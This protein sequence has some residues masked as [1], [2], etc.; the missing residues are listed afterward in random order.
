MSTLPNPPCRSTPSSSYRPGFRLKQTPIDKWSI[1]EKLALASSVHRSGDQNWYSVSRSLKCFG[2]PNRPTD[3]FSQKNCALQ[4]S[5]LLENVETPKRKRGE[6]GENTAQD[7]IVLEL[8]QK[9]IDELKELLI[10]EKKECIDLR[11]EL[12]LF[13]S[14]KAGPDKFK[15][16][17]ERMQKEEKN[18]EIEKE[19]HEK[20]LVEREAKIAQMKANRHLVMIRSPKST[21][22]NPAASPNENETKAKSEF[23]DIPEKTSL[24]E[25][26]TV[27]IE[28]PSTDTENSQSTTPTQTPTTT[29]Q[30]I[31]LTQQLPQQQTQAQ[32]QPQ[33]QPQLQP[34]PQTQ[35]QI[36]PQPQPQPPIQIQTQAQTP[37]S[38]QTPQ[39]PEKTKVM[40]SPVVSSPSTS[41]LLTHLLQSPSPSANVA[42]PYNILSPSTVKDM[43]QRTPPSTTHGH[44]FPSS[45]I[46]SPTLPR[47]PATSLSASNQSTETIAVENKTIGKETSEPSSI[48]ARDL[49]SPPAVSSSPTLTKLLETTSTTSIKAVSSPSRETDQTETTIQDVEMVEVKENVPEV[50][51]NTANTVEQTETNVTNKVEPSEESVIE[52]QSTDEAKPAESEQLTKNDADVVTISDTSEENTSAVTVV[53]AK[54]P[55]VTLDATISTVVKAVVDKSIT[56]SDQITTEIK[57]ELI[58]SKESKDESSNKIDIKS[59]KVEDK[60]E[61]DDN[62]PATPAKSVPP[63]SISSASASRKRKRTSVQVAATPPTAPT[64]RSVR[65]RTNKDKTSSEEEQAPIDEQS[66]TT[67]AS[68]TSSIT[69]TTSVSTSVVTT[70]SVSTPTSVKKAPIISSSVLPPPPPPQTVSAETSAGEESSDNTNISLV[71]TLIKVPTSAPTTAPTSKASSVTESA[72]NSPASAIL[73]SEEIENQKESKMW[74]KS[75][76]LLW[77][78]ATTHKFSTL[79]AHPVTDSEAKGYSTVVYRPMDLCTI[80]K[81]IENGQIKTTAEFQRDMMLM[82]QNAIMYNSA[83]HDVHQMAVEM[84]K[85]ILEGIEDFIETQQKSTSTTNEPT[86]PRGR[87]SNISTSSDAHDPE[88]AEL[89][90]RK[91]ASTDTEPV[92][93]PSSS[94]SKTK[95]KN[96]N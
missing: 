74:K 32:P 42:V 17:F 94:K 44:F 35:A 40:P 50:L 84:Q 23:S 81:K 62:P 77:R 31:P 89:R 53:D 63:V 7:L 96:P 39:T 82:F 93:T 33:P 43:Q 92:S 12:D 21:K 45:S 60:S 87:R 10:K 61:S 65:V 16:V 8:T 20:W 80:R 69:I 2:E 59:V 66:S 46:T 78:Q 85:E 88:S 64:R 75:I 30:Q 58:E 36:Q 22:S 71:P 52:T 56:S 14:G 13:K 9:R 51:T 86:K 55:T 4:Y 24:P 47:T 79:F 29:S 68:T 27:K 95:K 48:Q 34:Q 49:S 90:R 1:R 38:Q 83:D 41:P 19:E 15:E 67:T 26:L 11:D 37:Q 57:Q 54:I 3:W 72:P 91:R 28:P 73:T 18:K 6:R 25:P 5:E 76:M 70:D